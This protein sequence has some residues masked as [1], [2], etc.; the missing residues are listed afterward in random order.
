MKLETHASR[1]TPAI[2]KEWEKVIYDLTTDG[3]PVFRVH[4]NG[5]AMNMTSGD[6]LELMGLNMLENCS[7][8]INTILGIHVIIIRDTFERI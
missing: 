4:V 6:L 1:L 3:F 5:I 2:L 8:E 7:L